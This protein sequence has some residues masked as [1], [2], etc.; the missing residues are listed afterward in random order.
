MD[1]QV[2]I[3]HVKDIPEDE[4]LKF[5]KKLNRG[6]SDEDAIEFVRG[7]YLVKPFLP[8]SLYEVLG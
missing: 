8:C 4:C 1:S 2:L 6:L 7:L 3:V 5:V